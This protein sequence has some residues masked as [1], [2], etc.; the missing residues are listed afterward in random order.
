[1]PLRH[2]L[3]QAKCNIKDE[4]SWADTRRITYETFSKALNRC[5]KV[6]LVNR[7]FVR[8]EKCSDWSGSHIGYVLFGLPSSGRSEKQLLDMG[9]GKLED[10]KS[11]SHL[12]ELKG[13]VCTEEDIA[14]A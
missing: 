13:L 7:E 2:R 9:S 5:E 12:G 14:F 6:A 10:Q 4:D 11:S 3:T 1:M 8:Y